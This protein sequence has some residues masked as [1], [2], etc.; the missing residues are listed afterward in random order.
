MKKLKILHTAEFYDPSVGGAQEVVKQLSER[1]AALG[2]DVTVATTALPERRNK[3]INGVKIAEF[4][5]SGNTVRGFDGDTKAYQQFLTK[6]DFDVTMNYAV[7]QWT[8]DLFFPIIGQIKGKHVLVPCGF[9]ALYEPSYAE[10]YRAMPDV[11]RSY[12]ATVYMSDVYRDITFAREHKVTNTHVIANAAGA[13]EFEQLDPASEQAMRDRLGV[14]GL[15]ILSIGNHTSEKGHREAI[16][17]LMRA[18]LP[19]GATLVIQGNHYPGSGCYQECRRLAWLANLTTPF[20]KK[21][22]VLTNLPRPEVVT[23]LKAADLFLFLSNIECSPIVVFEAA[24]AG[25]PFIASDVGNC[26]EIAEWTGA[27]LITAGTAT[28]QRGKTRADIGSAVALLEELGRDTAKR[29]AMGRAGRAAWQARFTWE[30]ITQEYL[31]L[32]DNIMKGQRS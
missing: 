14:R 15:M 8:T 17:A 30:K 5:I 21:R 10:F 12:D 18:K 4:A 29:E 25:L 32:Y 6:S 2:H 24:A 27:G 31:D 1:M 11:L 9:S 23:A 7:Q 22:I 16:M 26:R 20:T 3:V 13:D 28:D 19:D